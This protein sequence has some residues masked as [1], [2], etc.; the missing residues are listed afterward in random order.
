MRDGVEANGP[1]AGQGVLIFYSLTQL[2]GSPTHLP[3][4]LALKKVINDPP[5][6]ADSIF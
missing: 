6:F 4:L 2:T 3:P 1:L 5:H